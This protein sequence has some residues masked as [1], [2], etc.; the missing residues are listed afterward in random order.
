MKNTAVS[1][2]LLLLLALG[3]NQAPALA[4][5]KHAVEAKAALLCIPG[6]TQHSSTYE[7]S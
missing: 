4:R 6:L 3:L 5:T 7:P 1:S 2:L